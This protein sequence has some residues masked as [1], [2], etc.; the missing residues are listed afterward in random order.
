MSQSTVSETHFDFYYAASRDILVKE[1]V[2]E[3]SN[4][5]FS[6]FRKPRVDHRHSAMAVAFYEGVRRPQALHPLFYAAH[7][8][9]NPE[10]QQEAEDTFLRRIE[11]RHKTLVRRRR[12]RRGKTGRHNRSGRV[13]GGA[14]RYHLIKESLHTPCR[15]AGTRTE[16]VYLRNARFKTRMS[17]NARLRLAHLQFF[18]ASD[19]SIRLALDVAT[20]TDLVS[21]I[22]AE[23]SG[24]KN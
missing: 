22:D 19:P 3:V 17:P 24:R 2:E 18:A 8:H 21:A 14:H 12:E 10:W 15:K 9:R 5:H 13:T 20:R 4:R 7:G 23:E 1:L 11:N 16:T 6:W